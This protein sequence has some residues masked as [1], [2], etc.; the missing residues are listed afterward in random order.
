VLAPSSY[1]ELNRLPIERDWQE[2][3]RAEKI[4]PKEHNLVGLGCGCQ[5]DQQR[6][7]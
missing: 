2:A 1:F 6:I 5:P 7:G 3:K 4:F